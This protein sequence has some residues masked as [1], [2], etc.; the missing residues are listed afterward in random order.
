MECVLS[1]PKTDGAMVRVV[2]RMFV[3]VKKKKKK[4][5]KKKT[6]IHQLPPE[7]KSMKGRLAYRLLSL[8]TTYRIFP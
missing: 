6:D 5:K 8:T 7:L 2:I 4:K 3:E 1:I